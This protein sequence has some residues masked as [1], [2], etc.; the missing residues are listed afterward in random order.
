M[1][2]ATSVDLSQV[3]AEHVRLIADT[4]GLR[5]V[6]GQPWPAARGRPAGISPPDRPRAATCISGGWGAF[7]RHKVVAADAA[8]KSQIGRA[9]WRAASRI[10]TRPPDAATTAPGGSGEAGDIYQTEES[11]ETGV[12]CGISRN[13][14]SS[15]RSS[16]PRRRGYC[17]KYREIATQASVRRIPG[18]DDG[19]FSAIR[20]TIPGKPRRRGLAFSNKVE[21]FPYT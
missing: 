6:L 17:S 3:P 10:I 2:T 9:H 16:D 20:L 5:R 18:P 19:G 7:P 14:A 21:P 15:F 8:D 1:Q 4:Q 13:R 12:L 11:A